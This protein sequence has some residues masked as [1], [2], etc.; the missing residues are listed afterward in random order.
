[1]LLQMSQ[2]NNNFLLYHK[3]THQ[4]FVYEMVERKLEPKKDTETLF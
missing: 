1:M 3:D 2:L 4:F